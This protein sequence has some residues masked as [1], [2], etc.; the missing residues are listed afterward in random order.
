MLWQK[1]HARDTDE[2]VEV[3]LSQLSQCI[4]YRKIRDSDM[5]LRMNELVVGIVET[6]DL[7][8]RQYACLALHRERA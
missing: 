8:R 2:T 4:V 1:D 3:R 6:D 5:Y 7:E